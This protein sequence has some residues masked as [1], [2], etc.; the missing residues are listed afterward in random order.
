MNSHIIAG[1]LG[2]LQVIAKITNSRNCDKGYNL[3]DK[4]TLT[5]VPA[6][7]PLIPIKP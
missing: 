2:V 7:L 4:L 6:G 5:K 1:D 3:L